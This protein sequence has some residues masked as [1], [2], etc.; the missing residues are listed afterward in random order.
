MMNPTCSKPKI[1]AGSTVVV[2]PGAHPASVTAWETTSGIK[3]PMT[4]GSCRFGGRDNSSCRHVALRAHQAAGTHLII[5]TAMTARWVRLKQRQTW[6][7][8]S[9]EK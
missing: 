7:S 5:G 6:G 3:E 1:E 9:R 2:V 4:W 8:K